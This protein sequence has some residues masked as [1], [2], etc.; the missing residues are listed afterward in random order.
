MNRILVVEDDDVFREAV[1]TYLCRCGYDVLTASNGLEGVEL[2]GSCPDLI[3]IVLTDVRMPV[4]MGSEAARQIWKMKPQARIICMTSDSEAACPKGA[5]FLEKPF[6][7]EAL[8]E[9]LRQALQAGDDPSA[10]QNDPDRTAGELD[11][12]IAYPRKT[13]PTIKERTT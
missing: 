13:K 7:F 12:Q 10:G 3:D 2:F 1:S 4:M 5:T 6:R 9:I 11:T 8:R